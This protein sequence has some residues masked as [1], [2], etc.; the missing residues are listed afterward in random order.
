M[1]VSKSVGGSAQDALT[2]LQSNHGDWLLFFDNADDPGINLNMFFPQCSHGNI[3]ITSRNPEL[4]VYG[5][6]SP[7]S[8]IEEADA[9]ALLLQSAAKES[10]EENAETATKIVKELC[11]LP[12]AIAQAGSFISQSEDLEGYLEL[13]K[14]NQA[15]LLSEKP[16]QS[17]DQYAWTV[18]TTWQISFKKLSQPAA[19]LLQLCSFLHHTGISEDIFS[20]ASKYSFPVWL[21]TKERLQEPLQ[22][23]SDF[24]APTGEWDSLSFF[25]VTKEIKAYSLI[26]FDAKTKMFFIH[27]LVHAWSRSTV[28]DQESSHSCTRDII[29]MS[30]SVVPEVDMVLASLKLM[31]HVDA[32]APFNADRVPDF[33]VA[34]WSI[35][36]GAGKLKEAQ[37]LIEQVC[38]AYKLSFGEEHLATLQAMHRLGLTYSDMGNFQR[39]EEVQAQVVKKYTQV[40]GEDDQS[41]FRASTNLAATYFNRGDFIKAKEFQDP[42]LEKQIR[43]LGEDHPE[44]LIAMGNLAMTHLHLGD[45]AKA[46][47]LQVMVLEKQTRFLGQDHP[48][49]LRAMGNLATIHIQLGDFENAQELNVVVVERRT[50]HLGKDHPDTLTAMANLA[51]IHSQLGDLEK[52]KDLEVMVFERRSKV[53][54]KDHLDTLSAMGNLAITYSRQADFVKAKELTITV[55]E[56]RTKLLGEDHL[57]TLQVMVNLAVIYYQLKEFTKAEEFLVVALE[58]RKQRLGDRHP[59]T[60]RAMQSLIST[61]RAL[62]KLREAEE[63]EQ[64]LKQ[65]QK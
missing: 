24:L 23:L 65:I 52:A 54:G 57:E 18:Y 6:H 36:W 10:S 59:S 53:L 31:P 51:A 64:V 55:L 60:I 11:Y 37:D 46:K 63:L 50:T 35:Y 29:G 26:S 2:W 7:V 17:H 40:V 21:P 25:K 48:I 19:T 41:A 9:I 14:K 49:T 28:V 22:F 61:Y 56:T 8:D 5:Q 12:L 4:R 45:F 58:K 13:Y 3:I 30:I 43:L 62:E 15:E 42:L 39:A 27:P 33:R 1:V 44:T 32:L 34:F 16:E 38:E 47:T 20:N